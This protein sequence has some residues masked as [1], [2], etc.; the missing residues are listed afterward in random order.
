[1]N[2]Q[3]ACRQSDEDGDGFGTHESCDQYDCDDEN[4]SIN[5]DSFEA[6]NGQD[7]DCDGATD[8]DMGSTTCGVG[9]CETVSNNCQNGEIS[10]CEPLAPKPEM[11]NA[12][13]DDCDGGVDED[14][15]LSSCGVGACQRFAMCEEGVEAACVPGEPV[16]ESCNNIDDDC[17]GIVD[18]G[19]RSQIIQTTYSDLAG[20]HPGCDGGSAREGAVCNA[21]INRFCESQA[22]GS[23]GFGP[24]E[25][26]GDLAFVTCLSGP[27]PQLVAFDVLVTHHDQ[28]RGPAD[29]TTTPVRRR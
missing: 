8:E 15:E 4:P 6:C 23:T 26:S 27:R 12:I 29:A 11:C 1:M 22:C 25:N 16:E 24:A 18:N 5:P 17:D 2:S 9:A 7:D 20:F 10:R 21:A 19:F 14:I 3:G 28:C 13:D